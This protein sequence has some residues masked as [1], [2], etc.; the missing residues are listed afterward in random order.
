MLVKLHN[1]KNKSKK[2]K[3]QY[4]RPWTCIGRNN[5]RRKKYIRH[6]AVSS[7][8]HRYPR[9][10]NCTGGGGGGDKHQDHPDRPGKD[11]E[12]EQV[13]KT[14]D[15]LTRETTPG[16]GRQTGGG[17]QV[18]AA[19][20]LGCRARQR[21]TGVVAGENVPLASRRANR[22]AAGGS[23]AMP[24]RISARSLDRTRRTG[25]DG[26]GVF[27]LARGGGGGGGQTT[28]AGLTVKPSHQCSA[29]HLR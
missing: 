26:V 9:Q 25:A 1:Y 5:E 7:S 24:A 2:T 29:R 14:M 23:D 4:S 22:R 15:G 3:S 18:V 20:P 13:A 27:G 28:A 11:Y 17:R 19:A 12:T 10:T 8:K 6:F 16:D 21:G